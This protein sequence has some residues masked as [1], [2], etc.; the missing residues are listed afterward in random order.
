MRSFPVTSLTKE[1]RV[2]VQYL[3]HLD[4]WLQ[5]G[6]QL[7]SC[8]F[9]LIKVAFDEEVT[10]DNIEMFR[11][12]IHR[13]RHPPHIF[14]HF[15]F[16][17]QVMVS[18]TPLHKSKE[19]NATLKGFAKKTLLKTARKAG[20]KQKTSSKRQKYVLPNM[21]VNNSNKYM[22]SPGRMSLPPTDDYS[23]DDD[24]SGIYVI[25]IKGE[26]DDGMHNLCFDVV[27]GRFSTNH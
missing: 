3:A 8:T 14:H 22:T 20:F 7:R 27:I 11:K 23:H 13:I 5:E 18:Q 6:L 21:A 26:E 17:G 10:A 24:L 4:Q 9:Q 16:T 2:A 1:K 19:K 25:S 12:L 15:A